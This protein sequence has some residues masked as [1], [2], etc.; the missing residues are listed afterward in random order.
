MGKPFIITPQAQRDF[1]KTYGWYE[2]QYQG[3][4]KEFARCVDAKIAEIQPQF[5]VKTQY[6]DST[7]TYRSRFWLLVNL[8]RAKLI[9]SINSQ[10]SFTN[11]KNHDAKTDYSC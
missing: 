1:D 8:N 10:G 6:A 5:E 3:L 7:H 4:G 9:V 11:T 2:E